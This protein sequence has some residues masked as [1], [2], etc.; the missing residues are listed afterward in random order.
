[1]NVVKPEKSVVLHPKD[2]PLKGLDIVGSLL[3]MKNNRG[4]W[5]G[6]VMDD[7]DCRVLF[8]HKYGPTVI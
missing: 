2:Y 6:T 3:L 7:I 5:T 4:W 1:M 8:G